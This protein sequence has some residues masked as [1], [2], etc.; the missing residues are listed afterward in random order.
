V[1]RVLKAVIPAPVELPLIVATWSFGSGGL[2]IGGNSG[3]G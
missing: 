3:P 1:N 2:M